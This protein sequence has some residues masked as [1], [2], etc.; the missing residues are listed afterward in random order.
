M[1]VG[2]HKYNATVVDNMMRVIGDTQYEAV[3]GPYL[4]TNGNE[5]IKNDVMNNSLFLKPHLIA[6]SKFSRL[7]NV[8]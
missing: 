1:I 7:C 4:D 5:K 3:T 6:R 8:R 2:D